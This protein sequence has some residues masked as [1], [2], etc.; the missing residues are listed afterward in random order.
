MYDEW[1]RIQIVRGRLVYDSIN[2]SSSELARYFVKLFYGTNGLPKDENAD[3][4]AELGVGTNSE[5]LRL[6]G[7]PIFDEKRLGAIHISFGRND[8][9]KGPLTSTIHH[10]I[11]CTDS[12]LALKAKVSDST[13][14]LVSLVTSGMF[15]S[16]RNTSVPSLDTFNANDCPRTVAPG[17]VDYTFEKRK[18]GTEKSN[19]LMIEYESERDSVKY[20]IASDKVAE[21][22]RLRLANVAV[23]E[24]LPVSLLIE[25]IPEADELLCKQII[26]GLV[27]YGVLDE[28]ESAEE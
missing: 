6:T 11:V 26:Q 24:F 18:H 13:V 14:G 22:A 15:V 9:F 1:L 4:L 7:N 8:Q 23:C 28:V 2:A 10:G 3:A 25:R 17:M 5:I 27:V 20:K 19:E 16:S 21:R 12:S